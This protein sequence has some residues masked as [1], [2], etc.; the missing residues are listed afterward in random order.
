MSWPVRHLPVVQNWDCHACTN[1]C[2]EYAV[3]VTTED[4]QRIAA[5]GWER[6]PDFQNRP[7]FV[8]VSGRLWGPKRY[9]LYH[10]EDGR[11]LFLSDEGRCRIHERFGADAK[12]LACRV[13][14]FALV[15]AGDHW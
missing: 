8:R 2:R 13:F 4:H 7:I 14:P 5:Q 11:C 9:R 15:P 1:C 12:P 3:P 6:E 10:H